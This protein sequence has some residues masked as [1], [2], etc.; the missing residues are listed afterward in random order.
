[1]FNV[2]DFGALGNGTMD[3]GPAIQNAIDRCFEKGGGRVF[4]PSG[5]LFLAGP[6]DLRS[7]VELYVDKGA[8]L[9]ASPK[10]ESF[11]KSAFR[12]NKGEGTIWIGGNNLENISISGGGTID[13]NGVSFMGEAQKDAYALKPFSMVDPRPH[14]LTLVNCRN[15]KVNNITFRDAAYW[16]LHFVGCSDVLVNQVSIYNNLKVRNSD[17]IDLDHSK[18]VNISNCHI[19]S[20]DDCICF[21]NRR[22][23]AEFGY[24]GDVTISNCTLKSTSCAIKFGSEN[25]DDI[26]NVLISNCVI[27]DSNRGIGIQ[28]RDEGEIKDIIV[29]NCIIKGRLFSDVWWGKAEPIYITAF[30]RA[31]ENHKDAGLRL[32]KGAKKGQVGQIRNIVFSNVLCESENGVF[33]AASESDK[34]FNIKFVEVNTSINNVTNYQGGLYDCRPCEGEDMVQGETAG[35]YLKNVNGVTLR[36]CSVS[37]GGNK[38]SYF[39]RALFKDN[40]PKLEIDNFKGDD[41]FGLNKL[42][43][44]TKQY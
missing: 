3:D 31:V 4:L 9:K 43:N 38:A 23:Y 42:L 34:I 44:N 8:V 2:K 36:N 7:N 37:W 6:F 28:N 40:C 18:N 21:K 5:H 15:I 33:V 14:L 32:P 12:D 25:M 41:A 1:M 27:K 22:E 17:G 30:P 39:G 19:E 24:C 26:K 10:E 20:G 29:S 16:G 11:T 13:G 35:F